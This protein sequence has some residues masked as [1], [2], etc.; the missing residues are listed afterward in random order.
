MQLVNVIA[1]FI[2]TRTL[3][4]HD[5]A[6][7][8]EGKAGLNIEEIQLKTSQL[9]YAL[10]NFSLGPKE[11]LISQTRAAFNENM[12]HN[13]HVGYRFAILIPKIT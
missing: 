13:M 7:R 9:K 12:M 3:V 2:S 11:L 5:Q 4:F 10:V 1:L 6:A 8:L